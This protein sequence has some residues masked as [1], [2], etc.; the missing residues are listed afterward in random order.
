MLIYT[1]ETFCIHTLS[2]TKSQHLHYD[3]LLKRR[4]T[5]NHNITCTKKAMVIRHQLNTVEM[6][7]SFQNKKTY[8]Y[9]FD[10]SAP[11]LSSS[12]LLVPACK[13]NSENPRSG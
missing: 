9:D 2:L 4:S 11:E 10:F 12:A 6:L 5:H 13:S 8:V 3:V 1:S 7:N